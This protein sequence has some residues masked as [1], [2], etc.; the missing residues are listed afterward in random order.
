MKPTNKIAIS[1]RIKQLRD[2]KNMT[3]EEWS[4]LFGSNKSAGFKWEN[5]TTPYKRTIEKMAELSNVTVDWILYGDF[6]DY[7]IDFLK[8]FPATYKMLNMFEDEDYFSKIAD[9]LAKEGKTYGDDTAILLE[10]AKNPT[11][12]PAISLLPEIQ[13]YLKENKIEIKDLNILP[14]DNLPEYRFNYIHMV[15][16]LFM[17]ELR[18]PEH[19]KLIDH[20]T[21]SVNTM[22][23]NMMN[24]LLE[25]ESLLKEWKFH[26]DDTV[27]EEEQERQRQD[28]KER[29][30]RD[31]L[32]AEQHMIEIMDVY[33]VARKRIAE[34]YELDLPKIERTRPRTY[35][36]IKAMPES[37]AE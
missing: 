14:V 7:V 11:N 31:S 10:V 25:Q 6:V 15:D 1:K 5:G 28:Q 16:D 12:Q 20:E 18:Y 13:N 33:R 36:E 8:K 9:S 4:A 26:V 24:Y 35:N 22:F 32:M 3:L 21:Y 17:S 34:K 23:G 37:L 19:E 30:I 29:Y 27:C 2:R